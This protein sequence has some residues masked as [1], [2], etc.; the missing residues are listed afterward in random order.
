MYLIEI[1][2]LVLVAYLLLAV[3]VGSLFTELANR[4]EM[5]R[6]SAENDLLWGFEPQARIIPGPNPGP[7]EHDD[8]VWSGRHARVE[9]SEYADNVVPLDFTWN[10]GE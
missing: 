1:N 8:F 4:A 7:P 3:A 9:P 10:N 5:R 2:T 6:L